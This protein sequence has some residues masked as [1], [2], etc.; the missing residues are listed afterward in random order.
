MAH[1]LTGNCKVTLVRH[2]PNVR[3]VGYCVALP[4]DG[5]HKR[6]EFLVTVDN[7]LNV[8]IVHQTCLGGVPRWGKHVENLL[9]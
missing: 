3:I 7:P 5:E 2:S 8:P 4:S 1:Y 9:K 6:V